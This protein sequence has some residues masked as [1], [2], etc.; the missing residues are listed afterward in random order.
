MLSLASLKNAVR[1]ELKGTVDLDPCKSLYELARVV[2]EPG[3]HGYKTVAIGI[4]SEVYTSLELH[5]DF[6]YMMD[7]NTRKDIFLAGQLGTIWGVGLFSD[8]Y[9]STEKHIYDDNEL[10]V[11][12]MNHNELCG[13]KYTMN[14]SE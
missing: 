13:F 10:V 9:Q 7:P 1:V 3:T 8:L 2:T 11:Y 6:P 5:L 12:Y 4:G 14:T